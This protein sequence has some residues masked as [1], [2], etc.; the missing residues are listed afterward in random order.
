MHLSES[1]CLI[2]VEEPWQIILKCLCE[3]A[4]SKAGLNYEQMK[5]NH[6]VDAGGRSLAVSSLQD[7]LLE[8]Q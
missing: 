5:M 7:L 1:G 8:A 3:K 2:E 6:H 4:C